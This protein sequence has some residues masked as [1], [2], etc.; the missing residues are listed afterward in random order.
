MLAHTVL[1]SSLA[2]SATTQTLDLLLA[3]ATP[4]DCSYVAAWLDNFSWLRHGGA[5]IHHPVIEIDRLDF[6]ILWCDMHIRK[7]SLAR[8]GKAFECKF[9]FFGHV[10]IPSGGTTSGVSRRH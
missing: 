10:P 2:D 6:R 5:E 7:N 4:L 8:A 1:S 9:T 3:P